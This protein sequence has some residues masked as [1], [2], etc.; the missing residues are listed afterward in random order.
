L[1]NII[2]VTGTPGVGKTALARNLSRES[3]FR[4]LDLGSLVREEKLYARFDRSRRSYIIDERKLRRRL[5]TLSQST[6]RVVLPTHLI[7][8]FLPKAAVKLALVL[9]LDPIILYKRL[10]A[11]GWTKQKA[12]E[13][14]EAEILDVS[15]QQSRRLLGPR[16]VYEIDTTHKP[17]KTIFKEAS[18]A[19]SRGKAGRSGVVNWLAHYDPIELK[20][21][22]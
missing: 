17:T 7:G 5:Q 14:T 12:W 13:N 8:G 22:L 19:L 10:R 20:R 11:R 3:G 15:L 6:E 16:R 21:A 1:A 9:R 18:R 2:L 4:L